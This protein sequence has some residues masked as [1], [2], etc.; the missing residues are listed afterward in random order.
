[1][2]KPA[3]YLCEAW[4]FKNRIWTILTGSILGENSHLDKGQ[5][6]YLIWF[7]L[8]SSNK[9][10]MGCTD[11]KDANNWYKVTNSMASLVTS[12]GCSWENEPT[13]TWKELELWVCCFLYPQPP[14]H[15]DTPDW[16]YKQCIQSGVSNNNSAP[17]GIL[18]QVSVL[19]IPA[20][21]PQRQPLLTGTYFMDSGTFHIC[22]FMGRGPGA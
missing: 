3:P 2:A 16:I 17:W 19:K 7:T 4:L 11:D 12:L 21:L 9:Q 20:S 10:H 8:K 6:G 13:V 18:V 15:S 5:S 1:M 14:P 22:P